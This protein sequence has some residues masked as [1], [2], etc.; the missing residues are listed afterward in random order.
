L[1]RS[2][3]RRRPS[4][5]TRTG[6]WTTTVF[7]IL[8]GACTQ[9]LDAGH[10]TA[11]P[12]DQRNPAILCNDGANDNWSGEYALLL[13]N[14]GGPRLASIIVTASKYWPDLNA[15][16]SGWDA[17]ATAARSS[18]LKDVPDVVGSDGAPL[19]RPPDGRID[20]TAANGSDG[21]QVILA[22]S[23]QLSRPSRPV[24]VIVG[25]RLTDVAD[26][27]LM[28][29]SV[30]DR[31]VVV[32]SLGSYQSPNARMEGPNGELD[33]WADWIVAQR[34]RYVQVSAYYQQIDDVTPENVSKLPQ[35]S[36]G[37]LMAAKQPSIHQL[38]QASDQVAPLSVGLPP[39][40]AGVVRTSVDPAAT[41][42]AVYGPPLVPNPAGNVWVVTQ[43]AAPRAPSRLWEMLLDPHTFGS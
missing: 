24:A 34:F 21:A 14:N 27:Y 36:F 28:D 13:A 2:S 17:L 30:V 6:P 25:T 10:G 31:V 5:A 19:S 42:D 1:S 37:T 16:I 9:T 22:L 4:L 3:P 32:A 20:A 8:A 43:N 33:P 11:L 7:A 15:N 41:F 12:V 23:R 26:A 29:H 40:V 18:G 38:P 39:F 35:N